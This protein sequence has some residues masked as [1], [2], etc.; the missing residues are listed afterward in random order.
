MNIPKNEKGSI[1]SE[2]HKWKKINIVHLE[3]ELLHSIKIK[4]TSDL[5]HFLGNDKYHLPGLYLPS[6]ASFQN[7]LIDACSMSCCNYLIQGWMVVYTVEENRSL[8]FKWN[9]VC[10]RAETWK[11]NSIDRVEPGWIAVSNYWNLSVIETVKNQ[12]PLFGK[13]IIRKEFMV[14]TISIKGC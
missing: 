9:R 12:S 3:R 13:N 2:G 6:P 8:M 14:K 11:T 1:D 4:K 7:F 5:D 10:S